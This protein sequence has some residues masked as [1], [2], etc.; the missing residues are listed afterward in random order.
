VS[1]I[2]RASPRLPDR[3]QG[4]SVLE[5]F[6]VRAIIAGLA[7]AIVAAP[8]GCFV[9]WQRMAYFGETVAQASLIGVA[10]S[11]AFR[12]DIT[13][14]VVVIAVLVAFL[15][16]WFGR[17]QVVALDS[18]LGLLHHAALATGVIA[19]SMLKGPP[20]DLLGFLFGDVFAVTMADIAWI[21]G[22][23]AA[24]LAIVAW[25]WQ[26]LLRLALH[27]DL[28]AAEGIDRRQ[29]R[30]IFTILLAVTIAVAM[31]IVGV[32]LVM[33]FL[34]VPAVAARP[35]SG[36]PERMVL[37]TALVAAASVVAG[38]GLSATFDTPGG[39]SIVI[40]MSIAAA[41]SLTAAGVMRGR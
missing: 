15:L 33:A 32:L 9:V 12:L 17:Q 13:L 18:I 10:L 28:A 7:L 35:L 40:V 39:P 25:L 11:L 24:V 36:T 38:L 4:T 20:V 27:E 1:R 5:P 26:P 22:G 16:L 41:A 29:V 3:P 14:G 8:L 2:Q 21:A 34:V 31:K 37:L 19:I 30:A 6:L 23:G